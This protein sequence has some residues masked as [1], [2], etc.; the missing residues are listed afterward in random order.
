MSR[1]SLL[2]CLALALFSSTVSAYEYIVTD[3]V[4]ETQGLP[5]GKELTQW[6]ATPPA[7]ATATFNYFLYVYITDAADENEF[8]YFQDAPTNGLY[9]DATLVGQWFSSD[10]QLAAGESGT[11]VQAGYDGVPPAAGQDYLGSP[12]SPLTGAGVYSYE[13]QIPAQGH[14][15][16]NF[17]YRNTGAHSPVNESVIINVFNGAPAITG[18][19]QFVGLRGQ[20]YQVHGIDGAVYNIISE[21]STQVNSRFVFLNQGQCP[22]INGK[23]DVN[24]WSHPG[25]YLGEMSFQQVVAGKVHA[26]LVQSGSAQK[27]FSGVQ[28]DGKALQV[29]DLVSFGSF[30]VEYVSSHMVYVATDNYS[31]E[32]SN[33]DEFINQALRATTPLSKLRSHGLLGQT[34]SVKTYATPL[35]YIEGEVDDYVIQDNDIFG[36]DFL[37]NQFSQ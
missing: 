36:T 12:T 31:F 27:G 18:D 34:H 15:L 33:S 13:F 35:K 24:C 5:S 26:A 20:S 21:E 28:V 25:S 30:S 1:F 19:P 10:N 7:Q 2:A 3:N 37:F 17:S 32:L 22:M 4:G 9:G 23:A 6:T 14:L 11:T 16:V 8:F 29:G